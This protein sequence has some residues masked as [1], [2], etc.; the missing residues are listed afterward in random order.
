MSRHSLRSLVIPLHS[1]P[2]WGDFNNS[3]TS[4]GQGMRDMNRLF[5]DMT[6]HFQRLEPRLEPSS[7]SHHHPQHG[8]FDVGFPD[9]LVQNP[10]VTDREGNR[11][12]NYKFDLRQ[13]KPEE[14]AIKS[15]DDNRIEVSAKHETND[16]DHHVY[17]EYRR[18][19]TLP[20]GVDV[21]AVKSQL[22]PSGVL[23]LE[24][25]LPAP[26]I[27]AAA[28]PPQQARNEPIPMEIQHQ[29]AADKK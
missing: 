24:A 14:I 8:F 2:F 26:A 3:L 28:K 17:R 4:M 5:D 18:V 7:H 23:T 16:S 1:D 25:P 15:Y 13:F 21:K 10:V 9:A 12:L 27:E 11:R 29:S 19:C 20:E 6:S 22:L